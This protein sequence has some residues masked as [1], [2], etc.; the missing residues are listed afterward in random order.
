MRRAGPLVWTGF[1]GRT[2]PDA[3]RTLL[4]DG[5]VGG[6][7]LFARNV[8]DARQTRDLVRQIHAAR[9]V[10]I[11]VDQE[12]GNVLRIAFGT[13]LPSAMAF[14]AV[15]DEALTERA[16]AT[17]A[18]E[19]RALGIGVDFAPCCDVNAEPANPVIGT[20]SFSD[21]PSRVARQVSAWI[22]GMQGAGDA[23]TAKHFPGHG[24]T[25]LDSHLALPTVSDD[26]GTLERRDLVPFRTAIAAGVAQVMTAHVVYPALDRRPGTYSSAINVDLLRGRLGFEGALCSDALEMVG[27]RLDDVATLA[28]SGEV[29]RRVSVAE[30]AAHAIAAGVDIAHVCQPEP[31]QPMRAIDA[32]EAAAR[33][34]EIPAERIAEALRRARAFAARWTYAPADAMPAP[35]H[36]LAL[37]IAVR[38]VTHVG[39]PQPDLRAGPVVVA[40]FPPARVTRAEELSR[41]LGALE[42]A[43]RRHFGSRLRFVPLPAEVEVPEGGAIAVVTSS[44]YFDAA[45]ATRARELLSRAQRAVL[46]AIRSP[47]DAAL[48][49]D[50]PALLT[51]SDVPPSCDALALVLAGER[52]AEGRL[53][54]RLPASTVDP[55]RTSVRA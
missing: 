42:Q 1:D 11:A 30:P 6:I 45:Q 14:G 29:R 21:D 51:Y 44:A 55:A 31:D 27:A 36:A 13:V 53:P 23:C 39:P 52:R 24:A 10:P 43:L 8:A 15:D 4:R 41:P 47:Y 28:Q 9:P 17:Q 35:D 34:G 22:R 32:I 40:A 38:A 18:R 12:G 19:L 49:P 20:R 50:V 33:S 3:L 16:A 7:S 37:E 48:F 25:D 26:A 46:C 5:D 54:V 2:L